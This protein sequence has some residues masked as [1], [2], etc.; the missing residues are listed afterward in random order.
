MV[1]PGLR[2]CA[3][4]HHVHEA[5]GGPLQEDAV[6]YLRWSFKRGVPYGT[7]SS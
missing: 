4:S 5:S 1:T 3:W 6:Y 7:R 2:R